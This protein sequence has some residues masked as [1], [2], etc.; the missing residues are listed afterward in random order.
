[1]TAT[2][3]P[4]DR[5][6]AHSSDPPGRA[7]RTRLSR[8]QLLATVARGVRSRALLSAGSVL[9][10]VLA[11]G[12]AV[13]GPVFQ[14]AVVSSYL[15]SRL[16]ESPNELTGLTWRFQPDGGVRDVHRAIGLAE[17]AAADQTHGPFL[18]PQSLV[19][20]PRMTALADAKV[21]VLGKQGACSHL[22]VQGRCPSRPGEILMLAKDLE[23]TGL[24]PGSAI[25][26]GPQGR[27]G[28][29]RLT[30]VGS[31]EVPV[32]ATDYWFLPA[33]FSSIPPTTN[34]PYQPAPFVT[35]LGTFDQVEP[36][37]Y[38]VLVDRRLQVP[39]DFRLSDLAPVERMGHHLDGRVTPVRGGTLTGDTIN[40]LT[41]IAR[42][43]ERQQSTAKASVTPAVI[44]LVLV[45][46]ALLLR[47]L[48]AAA[49]LRL[50][51]LALASLRGLP[52]RRMWTLGLSEPLALLG[53]SFPVGV[54]AGL[55]SS[56][57]LV[58]WW[59][60]PGLPMPVPGV[61]LASALVVTV[62]SVLVAVVAV[63]RVLRV[64]LSDQLTGVRRPQRTSRLGLIGQLALLA[65]AVAVLA[66]KLTAGRPGQPD[67][68][69]L[70]LP[71]LL[72]VVT[73]LA[74]T[75][76][77]AA[78]ASRWTRARPRARSLA[79]FVAARAISRRREGTLVILPLTAAIAICV[80]GAG[81]YQ[82]ASLWR[83]S[84]AATTAPAGQVWTSSATL[85][86]TVALTHRLDP[87][88]RWLM[89]AGQ[90]DSLGPTYTVVDAPRLGR[91][92]AWQDQWTPG[93]SA[94][95]IARRIGLPATVPTVTGS[96]VGIT[97]DNR[98][99][100][101]EDL[102]LRLR[103]DVLGERTHL[104]FLGPLASG[105]SSVSG[106]VSYCREGCLLQGMTLGGSAALPTTMTGTLTISDVVVDG[107][108]VASGIRSA[109]WVR[110]PD[111]QPDGAVTAVRTEG[112]RLVVA[113]DSG[114]RPA[115]G[116]IT[117]GGVPSR[118]P[119]VAGAHASTTAA[120]GS[121]SNTSA[122][123]F[124]VDP[125]I[126]SGS[127]PF[128]G[129]S[130]LMVDYD[131]LTTTRTID[132][133]GQAV[134][135]LARA[136]TPASVVLG[137]QEAGVTRST[138]LAA[139]KH[140][141]DQGAYALALRLYAVVA[142]LVLVMALAGLFVSTAVQLPARRRDAAS[143]RVVGMSRRSV[144]SSVVRELVVVLGGTALAGLAAGT[145]AEYVVLRTVTLGYLQDI[146]TPP[147]VAQ[148]DVQR[149]AVLALLAGGLFAV[150]A[151]ASAV[152]TV[153]G[154][155]GAT[156]REDAR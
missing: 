61:A 66:S 81:V 5:S 144:M 19:E 52:R 8:S 153:R 83:E 116:R 33:R 148:L 78:A 88:G 150:V 22:V 119:V 106:P 138:T 152:L 115:I 76:L 122:Y 59:L 42:E 93:T 44:S 26:T 147:L 149:L 4:K 55:G 129:P 104:L 133:Q 100:S 53:L 10:T 95:E 2:P 107:R 11:V 49:E 114:G 29:G 91:V 92:A 110:S 63:G 37:R 140:T 86:Q 75:R 117:S 126:T 96:R 47:L 35:S 43:I 118:L 30:V 69:D 54:I 40:D 90:I 1:M 51:E 102:Y 71:V 41:G 9:L 24:S 89:A 145:L 73:G 128:L 154:A 94:D 56:F 60:V 46:M 103:L 123:E 16:N 20:S 25:D 28:F 23:L 13:L 80:F 97:V 48:V 21:E 77:V 58:R 14:Q 125:V 6:P 18:P 135:V 84:V 136:D 141:L 151:V 142:G 143:L 139:V 85:D 31:Y 109:G 120:S 39:P 62:A 7:A 132:D 15:V 111:D 74:A 34:S 70:V 32:D 12:A 17:D 64:P 38:S 155:R 36:A 105:T 112:D 45:A 137:L 113:V 79:G 124:P 65:A 57:V 67:L 3:P 68:T 82:S 101:G 134:H 131:M 108:T 99:S 72:A 121:F 130:G 87:R 50:P 27:G 156:L 127:V 146:R 98:V